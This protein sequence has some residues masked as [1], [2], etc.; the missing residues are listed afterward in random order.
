M[1]ELQTVIKRS[2]QSHFW[3]NVA[4]TAVLTLSFS[5][6]FG[7]FLGTR[8]LSQILTV[9]GNEIQVTAYLKDDISTDQKVFLETLIRAESG[10]ESVTYIDKD[11]AFQSF[12]KGL[13]SYGPKFMES[14]SSAGENPFR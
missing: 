13:S 4:T 9:W 12:E 1:T 10:F 8:N 14:I 2:W 5:L 7:A 11:K 6:V 3:T